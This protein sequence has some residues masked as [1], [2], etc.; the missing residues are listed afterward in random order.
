[1][2]C[3]YRGN[4][5]SEHRD[6]SYTVYTS[7]DPVH[8]GLAPESHSV[9]LCLLEKNVPFKEI[10]VGSMMCRARLAGTAVGKG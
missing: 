6:Q 4:G 3:H 5:E 8:G 9:L 7:A 1:M 2:V 10:K